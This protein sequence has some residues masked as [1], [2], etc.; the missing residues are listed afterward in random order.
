MIA[1]IG[2][3]AVGKTTFLRELEKTGSKIFISDE[4]VNSIYKKG[5][6]GYKLIKDKL[7]KCFVD[8]YCVNKKVL[9]N[10]LNKD[11]ANFNLLEKII[12][13]LIEKELIDTKY[14]FVELPNLNSEVYPLW[15]NFSHIV[16][17][18]TSYEN[19]TKNIAKRNVDN[20]FISLISSKNNPESIKNKLFGLIPIVDIYANN[21]KLNAN[22]IKKILYA[23][24]IR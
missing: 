8:E 24:G 5:Q 15:K 1:I 18:N 23:L 22:N 12:Y 9:V 19:W 3:I 4:F 2:K 21:F 20:H 14:D 10:W 6:D 7:G 16:C 13:P 11:K 17:L